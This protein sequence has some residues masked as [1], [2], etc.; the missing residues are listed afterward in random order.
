MRH[1]LSFFRKE[2]K[3]LKKI[4]LKIIPKP[5]EGTATVFTKGNSPNREPFIKGEGSYKLT[6][7]FCDFVLAQGVELSGV[8]GIVL[9]CP[10][11]KKYNLSSPPTQD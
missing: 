10:K 7:G 8:T 1:A 2:V 3:H 11:C 9:H 5:D 6:C 4:R